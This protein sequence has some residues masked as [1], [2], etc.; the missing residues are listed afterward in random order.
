MRE[1]LGSIYEFILK[2]TNVESP[3]KDPCYNN[4]GGRYN[5]IY[6]Y[7]Y[8]LKDPRRRPQGVH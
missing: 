1:F 6:Q 8:L 5:L 3:H 7:S 2:F 4:K